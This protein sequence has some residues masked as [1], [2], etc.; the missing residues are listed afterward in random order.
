M[1]VLTAQGKIRYVGTSNFPGW[2]LASG[3]EAAVRRNFL[4]AVSEQC[5]YNLVTRE[6]E[7]EIIPAARAYGLGILVWS[8]LHSG[9][10]S[11]VLAKRR[12]NSSVKS[13][14]GRALAALERHQPTIADYE[15]LCAQ[16]GLDPAVTGLAWVLSRPGITS[17]VIGPRT[18]DQVDTSITATELTLPPEVQT[19]LEE[20]FPP[21]G[22]AEA[23]PE[24]WI[25]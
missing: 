22:K 4:G 12:T 24:A 5:L 19:R 15:D 17:V 14:Q 11:G 9:L 23:G 18:V 16:H 21:V 10:L 1:E 3:Q 7:L 6:P 8:P 20:L 2:R 25:L 13:A